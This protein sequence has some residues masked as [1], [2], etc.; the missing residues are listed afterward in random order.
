MYVSAAV[1]SRPTN[2]RAKIYHYSETACFQTRSSILKPGWLIFGVK[3][4]KKAE[5]VVFYEVLRSLITK[6]HW[7]FCPFYKVVNFCPQICRARPTFPFYGTRDRLRTHTRSFEMLF[8]FWFEAWSSFQLNSSDWFQM[9]FQRFFFH[10][11]NTHDRFKWFL[12]FDSK[13]DPVF[14][15]A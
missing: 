15:N 8:E 5:P 3:T 4:T 6:I 10:A 9:I 13:H 1:G 14:K 11:K 7:I 12:S 2:L